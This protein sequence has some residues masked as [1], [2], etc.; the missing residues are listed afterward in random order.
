MEVTDI[1]IIKTNDPNVRNVTVVTD[2][3]VSGGFLT[4]TLK[5]NINSNPA[6]FK[7][8][9]DRYYNRWCNKNDCDLSDEKALL[10]NTLQSKSKKL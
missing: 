8:A 5:W 7:Q 2:H 3:P 6:T 9:V 4:F 10:I 1:T